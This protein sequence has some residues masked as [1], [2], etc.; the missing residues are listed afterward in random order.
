ML[1]QTQVSVVRP[2]WR[3]FLDRFPDVSTLAAAPQEEVLRLWKGLGYY[4]RA[5]NLHRAAQVIVETHGGQL[6]DSHAALKALPG[7]GPYTAGAV[8]SI[9]FDLPAP[10]VDGNVARVFSRLF[11]IDGL[12]GD[13]AREKQLWALAEALVEG[14]RPGDLNQSLMELGA[15]VCRPESPDCPGCPVRRHCVALATDRVASLP[16]PKVRRAPTP[17]TLASAVWVRDGRLLLARREA[18]GLFG[19]LW[20]LPSVE[21]NAG[22][23]PLEALRGALGRSL[24]LGA[25]LGQVQRTLT[26]RALTIELFPVQKGRVPRKPGAGVVE[27]AWFTPDEAHALGMSTAMARALELAI[28]WLRTS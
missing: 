10:I 22:A 18:S 1:Q 17:M 4:G 26:H 23:E 11:G 6:P 24:E 8:A 9:A 21:L 12:P 20:E 14:P 16:P 7:F 13:R 25:S 27:L 5:R 19:G 2:Y 28:R 15:T 3:A